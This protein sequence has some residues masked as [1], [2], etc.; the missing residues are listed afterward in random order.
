MKKIHQ[1]EQ[2]RY[3]FNNSTLKRVTELAKLLGVSHTTVYA[4][5]AKEELDPHV[6]DKICNI[7]KISVNQFI[8]EPLTGRMYLARNNSSGHA[9]NEDMALLLRE[10][11]ELKTRLIDALDRIIELN[12]KLNNLSSK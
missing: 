5:Y 1:G 8:G 11:A 10:N 2:L 9:T 3:L 12:E 6:V 7:F 4:Y